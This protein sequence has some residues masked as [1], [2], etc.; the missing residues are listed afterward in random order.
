VGGV[1]PEIDKVAAERHAWYN[2][3]GPL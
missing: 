3:T 1:L 2:L